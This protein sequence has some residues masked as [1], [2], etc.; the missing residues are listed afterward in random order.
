M[1][2]RLGEGGLRPTRPRVALGII[3]FGKGDRHVNTLHEFT[4]VGFLRQVAIDS[5]KSYFDTNNTEHHH[6]YLEDRHEIIWK[7]GTSCWISRP[8]TLRLVK[9][10]CHRQATKSF[11]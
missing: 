8:L 10:P 9:S 3:L 1:K 4:R 5:S 11:A 2:N 7:I 6:Y